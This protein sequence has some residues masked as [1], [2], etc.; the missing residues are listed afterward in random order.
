MNSGIATAALETETDVYPAVIK[1]SDRLSD[2]QVTVMFSSS[3]GH[4]E[5]FKERRE[6]CKYVQE[7]QTEMFDSIP[8]PFNYLP[9]DRS[10]HDNVES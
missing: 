4:P 2:R 6:F 7:I 10:I 3:V 9:A 1:G 5:T 8:H